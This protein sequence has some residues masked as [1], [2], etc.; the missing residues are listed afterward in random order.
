MV[1]SALQNVERLRDLHSID[2]IFG[3]QLSIVFRGVIFHGSLGDVQ[4]IRNLSGGVTG[5]LHAQHLQ[6]RL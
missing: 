5:R 1:Q 4:L 3:V 6:R 2:E